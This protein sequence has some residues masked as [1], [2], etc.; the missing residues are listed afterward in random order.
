MPLRRQIALVLY[1]LVALVSFGLGYKYFF[2]SHFTDYH[3][4]A[5]GT[6]W[7]DLPSGVQ[8]LILALME[9]AGGGWFAL[10]TLISALLLVPFR[11]GER[12]ARIMIPV[13]ILTFYV[14]TLYATLRVLRDTP[15][16]PPWWGAALACLAA[17]VGL[18]L[19]QPWSKEPHRQFP[20]KQ[21][22][23]GLVAIFV[24][25]FGALLG[26]G[27]LATHVDNVLNGTYQT[28]LP[29]ISEEASRLHH[30]SFIVDLHA[31]TMLWDRNL[32]KKSLRG[33]VDLP[34]LKEGNIALQVF[35]A[36][37]KT[38]NK[39]KASKG[40]HLTEGET[41]CVSEHG[42][43]GINTTFWLQVAQLRP[44]SV[45]IDL[46]NR[47]LFQANRLRS[48]A[49]ASNGDLQIVEDVDDLRRLVNAR[50]SGKSGPTGA[51][52][53][54]EGAHWLGEN[55]PGDVETGVKELSDAG[56]RMLAPTHRFN[57]ALSAASEGC[58]QQKGLT[59]AGRSFLAAVDGSSI[60]LDLA[61]ASDPAI[62]EAARE[63][64]GPVV[65]SHTG[66]RKHCRAKKLC[67][68]A[69]NMRDEEIQA[70]A[71]T[72]GVVGLGVWIEA[73][74]HTM[75]DVI[76]SFVAAYEA[77]N[78]TSFRTEMES[79]NPDYDPFDHIAL[80]SDFDGAVE[81]P[82]DAAGLPQLT[83]ALM[84]RRDANGDRVF[85]DEAIR[86]IYGVNACRVIATRLP[87]GSA[88]AAKEICAPLRNGVKAGEKISP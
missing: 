12:W 65:I 35:A 67:D 37:T 71:R 36:V 82:I 53:A 14:P 72:G 24:I 46:K 51:L 2:S 84:E 66:V 69:R 54:L 40:L 18:F 26:G 49:V 8:T 4:K 41:D 87:G 31:D 10:F 73:A 77:L 80:G 44:L 3:Q 85:N 11:Q 47:A 34:R 63:V 70:I 48:F 59:A 83:Q 64:S 61:H 6:P 39:N 75:E 58:D 33:H 27:V 13:G 42:I 55:G 28:E 32:L 20:N 7:A 60:I 1:G 25:A 30:S 52:I 5:V 38:P 86:K 19:D 62:N 79:K 16:V 29:P 50:I 68:I 74:G 76:D 57:N 81:T 21:D 17:I 45:W 78:E 22:A 43:H 23:I 88:A 9:V 56:F 15:A